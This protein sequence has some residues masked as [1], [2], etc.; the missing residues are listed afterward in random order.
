[1]CRNS[2]Q[3]NNLLERP[4]LPDFL[5][6]GQE[7]RPFEVHANNEFTEYFAQ[8]YVQFCKTMFLQ[9]HF[10]KNALVFLQEHF[11]V[12]SPLKPL[13]SSR[14]APLLPVEL[15]QRQLEKAGWIEVGA[16]PTNGDVEVRAGSASGA[17]AQA[18]FLATL[19]GLSFFHFE[20][21]EME[22]ER[23]QSLTVVDHH[24]ISFE[25]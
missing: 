1:M 10:F 23:E 19:Y 5:F 6:F 18:D 2:R 25:I 22:V 12:L 7:N 24:A 9:E 20:F 11:S 16:L 14:F 17:A 21:G 15:G 4:F 8:L 3:I 13:W